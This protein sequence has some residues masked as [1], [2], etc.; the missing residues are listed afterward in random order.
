MPRMLSYATL[1]LLTL[2]ATQTASAQQEKPASA[3][4]G[5]SRYT[6]KLR[7]PT[8]FGFAVD[9]S[10]CARSSAADTIRRPRRITRVA[11]DSPAQRGAFQAG[12]TILTANDKLVS[13]RE[14]TTL[15]ESATPDT[16]LSFFVGTSR[17]RF[18]YRVRPGPAPVITLDKVTLPIRYRGEYA[19]VT[20]DVASNA[21][22]IVTRDSSGAVLIR[23]GE[24]VVRLH[25]AP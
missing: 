18:T 3:P 1:A 8:W 5:S 11:P 17:G 20:I 10:D 21:P 19:E 6:L 25:R 12:D 2:S 7:R 4:T 9:C 23:I 15:L 24:H 22:P 16:A 14:L 13:S